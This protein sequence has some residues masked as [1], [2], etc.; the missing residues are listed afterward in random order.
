MISMEADVD[1]WGFVLVAT[2]LRIID[3]QKLKTT[4][5]GELG[6]LCCEQLEGL[7]KFSLDMRKKF[8]YATQISS[9]NETYYMDHGRAS[10]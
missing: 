6:T 10:P 8:H 7:E 9:D 1:T 5:K 4:V 2:E 3:L